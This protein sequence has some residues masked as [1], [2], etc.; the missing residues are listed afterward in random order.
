MFI[1]LAIVQYSTDNTSSVLQSLMNTK[2]LTYNCVYVVLIVA[3][4]YFYTAITLNPT[5]MAEE[6][7]A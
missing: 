5:Q 6:Y 7:E 4:T 2:S 3:F 1:P